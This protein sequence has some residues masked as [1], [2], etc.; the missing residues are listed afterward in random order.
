ML[1]TTKCTTCFIYNSGAYDWAKTTLKLHESDKRKYVYTTEQ[2]EFGKTHD[3]LWNAAQ[4]GQ[5]VPKMH[6]HYLLW[7]WRYLSLFTM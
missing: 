7:K 4:V 6:V 5:N 2:L 3:Q 1:L